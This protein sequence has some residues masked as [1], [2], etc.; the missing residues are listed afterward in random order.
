M[1]GRLRSL[2]V[3][4]DFLAP[5]LGTRSVMVDVLSID[6]FS[7]HFRFHIVLQLAKDFRA[8]I[9][10]S[11]LS[12]HLLHVV[13]TVVILIVRARLNSSSRIHI[14]VVMSVVIRGIS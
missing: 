2:I 8:L 12:V 1:I 13:L 6:Q 9:L 3:L 10:D 4:E 5:T 14:E 7:L 11:H